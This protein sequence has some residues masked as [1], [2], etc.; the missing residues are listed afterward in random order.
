MALLLEVP[1]ADGAVLIVEVDDED[2]PE[3]LVLASPAV[4]E[5]AAKAT[6]SLAESLDQLEPLLTAV[7]ERLVASCPDEFA[8]EFGVKFG[9][10]TGIILAKGT[11]E[12]NLNITMT[13]KRNGSEQT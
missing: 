10:E 2:I 9:G 6:R 7:R 12:V 11:A 5:V 4:G 1:A 8:V 13:W 3:D